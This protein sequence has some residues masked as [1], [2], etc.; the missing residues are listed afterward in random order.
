MKYGAHQR[1][2]LFVNNL[3]GTAYVVEA[4]GRRFVVGLTGGGVANGTLPLDEKQVR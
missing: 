4:L 2:F 1:S 3:G